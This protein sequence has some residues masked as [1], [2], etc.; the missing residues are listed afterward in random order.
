VIAE[1]AALI[2]FSE[3]TAPKQFERCASQL[4]MEAGT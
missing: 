1:Q 4:P 3:G 2:G